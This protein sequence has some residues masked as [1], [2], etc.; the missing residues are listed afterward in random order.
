MFIDVDPVR[1]A[2]LFAVK[3]TILRAGQITAIAREIVETLIVDAG[4]AALQTIVLAARQVIVAHALVDPVFLTD[5]AIADFAGLGRHRH[6]RRHAESGDKDTAD[7]H[8]F[9]TPFVSLCTLRSR[10][11]RRM[12]PCMNEG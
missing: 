6:K 8:D 2:I 7:I 11:S 5:F 10:Y 12:M 4:F 9:L 1:E 3:F